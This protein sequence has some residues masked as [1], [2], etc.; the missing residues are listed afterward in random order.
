VSRRAAAALLFAL[1]GAGLPACGGRPA[2]VVVQPARDAQDAESAVN[3]VIGRALE[4]DARQ[5]DPGDTLYAPFATIVV[6]GAT[7]LTYPR[8]AGIDGPGQVAI[9]ASQI[10]IRPAMAWADVDY[11]WIDAA[12]TTIHPARATLILAPRG[13]GP[14]W[15]IVHAHSSTPLADSPR[16]R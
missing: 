6:D 9:T 12:G 5:R 14:G 13:K 15:W 7:R 2:S 11:R 4:A 3:D 1:G 8:F 16:A 10:D